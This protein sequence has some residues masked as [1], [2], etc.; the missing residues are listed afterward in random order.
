MPFRFYRTVVITLICFIFLHPHYGKGAESQKENEEGEQYKPRRWSTVGNGP[1]SRVVSAVDS[2]E[3]QPEESVAFLVSLQEKK[4][5]KSK[6]PEEKDTSEEVTK[7]ELNEKYDKVTQRALLKRNRK[8][9]RYA[10]ET[11]STRKRRRNHGAHPTTGLPHTM[12]YNLYNHFRPLEQD[13][14]QDAILPFLDFGRKLSKGAAT[15]SGINS[16]EGSS[17]PRGDLT[18]STEEIEDEENL[19]HEDMDVTVTKKAIER[20][21]APRGPVQ[22]RQ[23]LFTAYFKKSSNET[24]AT[25]SPT[26][27]PIGASLVVQNESQS[28]LSKKGNGTEPHS[29]LQSNESGIKEHAVLSPNYGLKLNKSEISNTTEN[30]NNTETKPQAANVTTSKLVE[31]STQLAEQ[32]NNKTALPNPNPTARILSTAVVTSVSV[33]ES[34]RYPRIRLNYSTHLENVHRNNGSLKAEPVLLNPNTT[35]ANESH[36]NDNKTH[37]LDLNYFNNNRRK[38]YTTLRPKTTTYRPVTFRST[39]RRNG[40]YIPAVVHVI[41]TPPS[42]IEVPKIITHKPHFVSNRTLLAERVPETAKTIIATTELSKISTTTSPASDQQEVTVDSEKTPKTT[43]A[44]LHS[45]TSSLATPPPSSSSSSS[46][47]SQMAAEPTTST[48]STLPPTNSSPAL[49][50]TQPSNVST[51]SSQSPVSSIIPQSSVSPIIPQSPVSPIIPPSPDFLSIPQSNFR[52]Q[53]TSEVSDS[54]R[55][56]PSANFVTSTP[57]STPHT[58]ISTSTVMVTSESEMITT[59]TPVFSAVQSATETHSPHSNTEMSTETIEDNTT[60]DIQSIQPIDIKPVE[61]DIPDFDEIEEILLPTTIKP[62]IDEK[63]F[64]TSRKPGLTWVF[65]QRNG[66]VERT[67]S[68]A[69]VGVVYQESPLG[70]A[71]YILAGLGLIPLLLGIFVLVR[72]LLL[73]SKKKVLDESEYSSEY[74]RSPLPTKL[75]RVPAHL[76]WEENKSVPTTVIQPT[77]W[78]FSR[79]KLRLQTVLGQG[80]FGQVWKAEADDICDHEGLTRLVAVKTVKEGASPRE[81][82]DLLREL[83]IMQELGAHPNVVTLLGCCTEKEPYLLIMEYVMY[84]KLLA[85]LREHRTRAH[86]FNFSD[87]SSALTSRDLTVFS[88]CVARGMEYLASKGIIHRD[89]AARNI[90]VDHN[91][92]CKIAD[93]GMSRNVRDTGQIYEQRP[94]RGALPIRWMAPESLHYSQFTHSSDV[95]SFGIL[96]WEIITLGSTPYNTMGAREVMRQVR[97]GYRLEKPKHCKSEFYKVVTKCWHSDSTKRPS[98]TELKQDIGTLLGDKDT[99]G[100]YVDLEALAEEMCDQGH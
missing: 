44:L 51:T 4:N 48:T 54:N 91:K 77:K 41:S 60:A 8:R 53:G 11:E 80:N 14:P 92:L 42:Y 3:L 18:G 49:I 39:F 24:M 21:A 15:T 66:S 68:V 23:P 22:Q 59:T 76:N 50:N 25:E 69:G 27:T 90:L 73:K 29:D 93:F 58:T 62:V 26:T 28:D 97:D 16:I 31:N 74:N 99:E 37:R 75:P 12:S 87:L 64:N 67:N 33:K 78:E 65:N 57:S 38:L 10:L 9:D 34:L 94:N 47:T 100:G 43:F 61:T 86:Y 35:S 70:L 71:T 13:V 1:Y 88:Y 81:K 96:L 2:P 52:S 63:N 45:V 85:F 19:F 5:V 32:E 56:V 95:W 98:F 55:D 40:S 6:P 84:G 46:T 82:E 72:Q 79:D 83:G 17:T 36:Q 30:Q 7:F 20:N 89:L